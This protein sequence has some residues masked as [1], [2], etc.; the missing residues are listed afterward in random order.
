M[1]RAERRKKA[2]LGVT[3]AVLKD[4]QQHAKKVAIDTTTTAIMGS[5]L[6]TL[7]DEFGWGHTRAA[8]LMKST[9]DR[10]E[11]MTEGYLTIEDIRNTVREELG[12]DL[13]KG[14]K[15]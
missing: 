1:N 15:A 8:R 3:S 11:A 14:G 9:I 13:T 10:F 6:L 7:K 5:V 12:I 2:K 4:V